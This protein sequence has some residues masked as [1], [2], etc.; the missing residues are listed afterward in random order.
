[1][2]NF[3]CNSTSYKAE[4]LD[5]GAQYEFR[6]R[7]ENIHGLSEPSKI[8]NPVSLKDKY[9]DSSMSEL[10]DDDLESTSFQ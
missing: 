5:K 9:D 7:A 2:C 3:R 4:D 8:S 1:M 10:S 6:V